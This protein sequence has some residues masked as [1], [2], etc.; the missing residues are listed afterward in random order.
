MKVLDEALPGPQKGARIAVRDLDL[1]IA[2][3]RGVLIV[4]WKGR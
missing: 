2:G 4:F 1:P 3:T